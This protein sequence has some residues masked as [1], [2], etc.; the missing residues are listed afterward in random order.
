[1][2]SLGVGFSWPLRYPASAAAFARQKKGRTP[3]RMG[4]ILTVRRPAA[5]V[6]PTPSTPMRVFSV[7]PYDRSSRE[8]ADGLGIKDQTPIWELNPTRQ[9]GK[10]IPSDRLGIKS[11][12]RT[13]ENNPKAR[14]PQPPR[15]CGAAL[16]RYLLA[17]KNRAKIVMTVRRP[18]RTVSR[19]ALDHGAS[20]C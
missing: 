3:L 2:I 11:Q 8:R 7:E 17:C 5:T 14:R 4:P 12:S 1:M 15:C 19:S 9:F 13:W 6:C 18:A 10:I 20:R 16:A